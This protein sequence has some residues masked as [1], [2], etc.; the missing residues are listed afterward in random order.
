MGWKRWGRVSGGLVL[1]TALVG[2]LGVTLARGKPAQAQQSL[3]E[4]G[5]EGG[6][7]ARRTEPEKAAEVRLQAFNER[8]R[9]RQIKG[10]GVLL[11]WSALNLGAGAIGYAQTTG[12][13]RYFH[14][15][16]AAWNV[17]N[18]AIA[19]A[20][21]WGA[22]SEESGRYDTVDTLKKAGA[23]ERVLA[24]N[25]GLN[26]AYMA[27]GAYLWERG[28][29]LDDERLPGYGPSLIV[30]GAFLLVFDST[31]LALQR[32][33]SARLLDDLRVGVGPAQGAGLRVM[34]R[35]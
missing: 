33:S 14:Q 15:M 13:W 9:Q 28:R 27:G 30:Q 35:F 18:A 25:I 3:A 19:G 11:G 31:L 24:L 1:A 4:S 32:R 7:L 2:A 26:V 17:V 12:R 8:R 16:N 22:L 6:P 23:L 10:M 34:G 29:R 5:A 21:L 20:G